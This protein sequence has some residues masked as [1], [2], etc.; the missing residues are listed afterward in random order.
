MK[1]VK[2]KNLASVLAR[3]AIV[4]SCSAML[5][6]GAVGAA[7]EH[8]EDPAMS[9]EKATAEAQENIAEAKD[10]ISAAQ[11]KPADTAAPMP[12]DATAPAAEQAQ[13]SVAE[14]QEDISEAREDVAEASENVAEEK[15]D[16]AKERKELA[17]AQEQKQQAMDEEMP[18]VQRTANSII[19][20]KIQNGAGEEI[21]E[22]SDIGVDWQNAKV[23][24]AVVTSGGIMG[25]GGDQ[26]KVPLD[27][28][29]AAPDDEFFTM[30][31]TEKDLKSEF[32]KF[33]PLDER[34][35]Q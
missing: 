17:E 22:V 33:E 12:A 16:L 7:A 4:G 18:T 1:S 26:F 8:H 35:E 30:D 28:L 3:T 23:P 13:E 25:V 32:S 29:K 9:A 14:A 6:L 34:G 19:G 31:T 24:F 21:G 27:S 20:K 5:L 2:Q 15:A 10:E 11:D